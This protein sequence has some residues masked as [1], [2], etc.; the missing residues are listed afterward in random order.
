MRH[1]VDTMEFTARPD[2]RVNR[3]DLRA[4]IDVGLALRAL[5][6]TNEEVPVSDMISELADAYDGWMPL[7]IETILDYAERDRRVARRFRSWRE[8][9]AAVAPTQGVPHAE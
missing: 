6:R 3:I 4:I 7:F 8:R 9:K 1:F 5:K 2:V